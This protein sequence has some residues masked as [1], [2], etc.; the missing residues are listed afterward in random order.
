[1]GLGRRRSPMLVLSTTVIMLWVVNRGWSA[2]AVYWCPDHPVDQRYSE[3]LEPGC[4]PLV[5]ETERTSRSPHRPFPPEA[6]LHHVSEF[7]E[8]YR[9]FLDCCATEVTSIE[10]AEDLAE[11]AN[12]LLKAIPPDLFMSLMRTRGLTFTSIVTQVVRA[13]DDLD[14][15][16]QRLKE[17]HAAEARLLSLDF[18]TAWN[19]RRHQRAELEAFIQAIK[20]ARRPA[21]PLTGMEI[22]VTPPHGP[23]I[24]VVPSTGAE[25]GSVPPTGP[26]IGVIPPTGKAIG[27]TPPTGVEIG[28]TGRVGPDIGDGERER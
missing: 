3:T 5:K 12:D 20:P 7:L 23:E 9:W 26:E 17:L 6:F 24:G 25:T 10:E 28:T 14:R 21:G 1:M 15:I 4:V 22:G 8:R 11:Q 16:A 13:R 19:E 18:L 27:Q 2:P